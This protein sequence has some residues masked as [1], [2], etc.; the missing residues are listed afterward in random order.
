MDEYLTT[1][2]AAELLRV[3]LR[4]LYRWIKEGKVQ[5]KRIG[6]KHLILRTDIPTFLRQN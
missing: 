3:S 1:K 2:E 4:T 6:Q 5:T